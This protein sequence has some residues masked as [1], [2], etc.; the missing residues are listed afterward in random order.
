MM[1]VLW[2]NARGSRRAT[3]LSLYVGFFCD[4]SRICVASS[5]NWRENGRLGKVRL[6]VSRRVACRGR[7]QRCQLNLVAVGFY[8]RNERSGFH[9]FAYRGG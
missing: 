5:W 1:N 3:S 4:F 7:D 2:W 9:I 6:V 8:P